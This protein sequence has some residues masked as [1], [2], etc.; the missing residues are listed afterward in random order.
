MDHS[1]GTIRAIG[2]VGRMRDGLN[3]L[4]EKWRIQGA[5]GF[6]RTYYYMLGV[7]R[8]FASRLSSPSGSKTFKRPRETFGAFVRASALRSDGR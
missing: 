7:P 1:H 2:F 6:V 5:T 8:V 4:S 3:A